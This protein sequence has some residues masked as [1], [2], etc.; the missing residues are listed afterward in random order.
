MLNISDLEVRLVGPGKTVDDGSP[1][2]AWFSCAFGPIWLNN[3]MVVLDQGKVRAR[4]PRMRASGYH[5]W[6]PRAGAAEAIEQAVINEFKRI[7]D[8]T[9]VSRGRTTTR[10]G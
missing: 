4:W 8:E 1:L 7:L 9:P 2:L 5:W 3:G 10:Q 6:Q